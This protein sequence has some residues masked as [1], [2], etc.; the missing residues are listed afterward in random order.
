[1]SNLVVNEECWW[2]RLPTSTLITGCL[3]KMLD[4]V[5]KSGV[6]EG[7]T[8]N[9]LFVDFLVASEHIDL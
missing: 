5:C 6:Y 7:A 1:M 4:A 2:D 3:D 9:T 8:S